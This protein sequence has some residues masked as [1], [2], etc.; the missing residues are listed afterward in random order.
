MYNVLK[1]VHILGVVLFVGNIIVT[2]LWKSRA[3]ESGDLAT[4]AFAQRTVAR[5]DWA[6]TLPGILLVFIGGY[7]M[8][9]V[10]RV[11]LNGLRWLEWGQGLFY[12]SALIWLIVLIPTNAVW[13][14]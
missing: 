6:F 1:F 4:V 12:V 8:A 10:G 14:R 2:A 13:S 3:D 5:T 7:G 9:V 11:P